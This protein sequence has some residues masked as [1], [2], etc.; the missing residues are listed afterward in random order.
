MWRGAKWRVEGRGEMR[1]HEYAIHLVS[2]GE[3]YLT[4]RRAPKKFMDGLM[5]GKGNEYVVCETD[6]KELIMIMKHQIEYVVEKKRKK[7]L[8]KD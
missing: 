2:G 5:G 1:K 3:F 4:D 7:A 6:D 8:D